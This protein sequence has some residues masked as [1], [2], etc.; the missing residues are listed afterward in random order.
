MGESEPT[1]QD[2]RNDST[3]YVFPC[4][5]RPSNDDPQMYEHEENPKCMMCKED[6]PMS[7]RVQ[8]ELHLKTKANE[9]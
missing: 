5:L 1:D 3:N 2:V 7:R 6:L 9:Q 4:A 8:D